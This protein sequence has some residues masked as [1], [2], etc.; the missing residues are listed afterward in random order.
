M[1]KFSRHANLVVGAGKDHSAR[2][3]LVAARRRRTIESD[4]ATP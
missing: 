1:S 3:E 4:K 2:T